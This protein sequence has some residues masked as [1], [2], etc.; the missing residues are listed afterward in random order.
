MRN[1]AFL[2]LMFFALSGC[3]TMITVPLDSTLLVEQEKAKAS[4]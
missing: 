2:L 1:I 3:G 4:L